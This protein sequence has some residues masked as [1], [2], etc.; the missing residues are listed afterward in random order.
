MEPRYLG[1]KM[2]IAKSFARIHETN[3]KKQGILALTFKQLEDY[4][5]V[6]EGDTADLHRL[7]SFAPD[8]PFSLTLNH[9]D[10]TR[11]EITLL[12]SYNDIQIR[13]FKSG[14]ALNVKR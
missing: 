8:T 11:D 2:I 3:L 5:K 13:W 9:R 7:S 4:D 12:H 10:G 6:R 1:V 14:A